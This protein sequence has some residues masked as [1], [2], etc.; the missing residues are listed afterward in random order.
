[1]SILGGAEAGGG[2]EGRPWGA[3]DG[4]TKKKEN[5][6]SIRE[7]QLLLQQMKYDIKKTEI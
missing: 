6:G 4:E 5:E 1:M 3:A 2:G 7:I